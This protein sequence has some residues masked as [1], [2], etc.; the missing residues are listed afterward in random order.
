MISRWPA[1]AVW[2]PTADE[3]VVESGTSV[4]PGLA[5]E[6]DDVPHGGE[7]ALCRKSPSGSVEPAEYRVRARTSQHSVPRAPPIRL[8]LIQDRE[9]RIEGSLMYTADDYRAAVSLISSGAANTD[10]IITATHPL[11]EAGR[12][13]AASLDPEQVKVIVTTV[14]A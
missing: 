7:S 2:S 14:T 6:V 3:S 4:A 11:G 9:N 13:F 12:A 8:D 10:D 5:G 1:P